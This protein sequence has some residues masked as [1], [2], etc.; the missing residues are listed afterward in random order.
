LFGFIH[1]NPLQFTIALLGGIVLHFAYVASRSLLIPML[2]HFLNNLIDVAAFSKDMPIPIGRSLEQAF[3]FQPG[4]MILASLL[5]A[6]VIG[7]VFYESRVRIWMPQGSEAP[8]VLYPH[9]ELP[10]ATSANQASAGPIPGVAMLLLIVSC[11]FFSAIWF[12]L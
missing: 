8:P 12:G 2:L 1:L 9:V 3:E 11:A 6:G 7:W 5:M 4:M 10:I